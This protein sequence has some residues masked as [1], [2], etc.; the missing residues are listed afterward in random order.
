MSYRSSAQAFD[1]F[2]DSTIWDDML[3][4]LNTWL[5]D[6]GKILEDASGDASDKALHR[7]GGNAETIRNVMKMPEV[8]RDSIIE[9][10]KGASEE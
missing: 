10:R 5:K 9:D 1:E 6:V 2:M 3:Q 8:I 4:E 7:L